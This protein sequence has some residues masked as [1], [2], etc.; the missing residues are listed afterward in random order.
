LTIYSL[1]ESGFSVEDQRLAAVFVLKA[2]D[3][4]SEAGVGVTDSHLALQFQEA[5]R[6]RKVT[7]MANQVIEKREDA[8]EEDAFSS[9]LRVV[10]QDR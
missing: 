2:S 7:F 5:L 4:L 9:L 8:A 1:T 10:L 3:I 6:L